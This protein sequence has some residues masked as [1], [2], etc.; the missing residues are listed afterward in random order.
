[1]ADWVWVKIFLKVLGRWAKARLHLLRRA[2]AQTQSALPYFF[3]KPNYYI[4]DNIRCNPV[5]KA[6]TVSYISMK[7]VAT[8]A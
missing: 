2:A 7:E 1:V 6:K 8:A 5:A 3:K 4:K